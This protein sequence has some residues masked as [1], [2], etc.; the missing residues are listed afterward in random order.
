MGSG[1]GQPKW[2]LD[3]PPKLLY[4]TSKK[5]NGGYF[6]MRLYVI[7]MHA[8]KLLGTEA[9]TSPFIQFENRIKL[10]NPIF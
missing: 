4:Y 2:A 8:L 6:C 5:Q 10:Q 1:Q 9:Q 7:K 3:I